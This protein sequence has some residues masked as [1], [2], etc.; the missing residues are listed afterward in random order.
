MTEIGSRVS[1]A[2]RTG[3]RLVERAG[4]VCPLRVLDIQLA[5]R[6]ESLA[7]APVTCRQDAVKHVDPASHGLNKILGSSDAHQVSRGI[8]GHAGRDVF[9]HFE[10]QRL[11]FTDAQAADGVTVKADVYG[12][13]EAYPS[14]VEMAGALDD[15]K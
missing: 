1:L 9:D 2:D 5:A 12:L 14:Q 7:S 11:L 10:H 15:A 13:F 3:T 8:F 4:V 6:G